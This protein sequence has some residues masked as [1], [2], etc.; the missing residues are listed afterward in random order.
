ME[1][2][3]YPPLLPE[4]LDHRRWG[5][6][7]FYLYQFTLSKG[8]SDEKFFVELYEILKFRNEYYFSPLTP[9]IQE[10]LDSGAFYILGRMTQVGHQPTQIWDM[11]KL[12]K[13]FDKYGKERVIKFA[14]FWF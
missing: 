8:T 5:F 4:M 10:L 13:L 3:N 14:V 7:I 1:E 2:K 6:G 12:K 9:E 11:V